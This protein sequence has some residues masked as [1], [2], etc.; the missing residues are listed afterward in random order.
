MQPLRILWQNLRP[1]R[2][3]VRQIFFRRCCMTPSFAEVDIRPPHVVQVRVVG[4]STDENFTAY[5][6]ATERALASLDQFVVLYDTGGLTQLPARHR[7]QFNTWLKDTRRRFEGR[8]LGTAFVIRQRVL[9][10]ALQAM[11]WLVS[12]Y[13]PYKVVSSVDEGWAWLEQQLQ[14]NGLPVPSRPPQTVD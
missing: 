6:D 1:S 8:W 9:R 2:S 4:D 11:F 13:Y 7:D 5:I 3:A 14:N 10:G 12:P